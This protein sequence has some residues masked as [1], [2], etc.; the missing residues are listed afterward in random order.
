MRERIAPDGEGKAASTGKLA[1]STVVLALISALGV[2]RDVE[3]PDVDGKLIILLDHV[4]WI[5]EVPAA[6][7][8]AV[9]AVIDPVR[10]ENIPRFPHL[11]GDDGTPS[12][13]RDVIVEDDYDAASRLRRTALRGRRWVGGG[14]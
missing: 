10:L 13:S 11:D 3:G 12:V 6:V 7:N 4:L 8:M 5:A 9:T 1:D 14:L 2:S